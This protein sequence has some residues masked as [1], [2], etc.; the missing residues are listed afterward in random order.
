MQYRITRNREKQKSRLTANTPDIRHLCHFPSD[1]FETRIVILPGQLL[2]AVYT[3]RSIHSSSRIRFP[4]M[5]DN[6]A[7]SIDIFLRWSPIGTSDLSSR[8]YHDIS[9]RV[10]IG[11]ISTIFR[12]SDESGK[13]NIIELWVVYRGLEI[14][15]CREFVA[16]CTRSNSPS[17]ILFSIFSLKRESLVHPIVGY[18]WWGFVACEEPSWFR[19]WTLGLSCGIATCPDL[20]T[21]E[22]IRLI[23]SWIGKSLR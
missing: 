11:S 1:E 17:P 2:I 4:E 21:D 19:G 3:I 14:S 8:F 5:H 22:D 13:R 6:I 15:S 12:E 9:I 20:T 16:F 7:K 23:T 10:A 18:E